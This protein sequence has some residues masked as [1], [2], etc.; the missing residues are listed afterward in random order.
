MPVQYENASLAM[1]YKGGAAHSGTFL[2]ST[3]NLK[4]VDDAAIILQPRCATS[5]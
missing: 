3:L 5:N 4:R 1:S 2:R